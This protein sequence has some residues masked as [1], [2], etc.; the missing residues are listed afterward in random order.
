[1]LTVP[2]RLAG[3]GLAATEIWIVAPPMPLAGPVK[4]IHPSGVVA[5]QASP[6]VEVVSTMFAVPP[7]AGAAA[8]VGLME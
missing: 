8:L 5:V 3:A 4:L 1:M 2:V 7:G 6:D